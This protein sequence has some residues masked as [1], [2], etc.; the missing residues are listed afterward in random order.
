ML[1]QRTF[2]WLI[3]VFLSLKA[4]VLLG[5]KPDVI[6]ETLPPR[7][8]IGQGSINAMLQD[9]QGF[10]WF[11]TWSGLW[12]YDAYS[13]RPFGYEAGLS[14]SKITCLFEEKNGT[15]WVG[16]R[17]T[18]LYRF[19]RGREIF[20]PASAVLPA[21]NTLHAQNITS[22]FRDREG[23]YWIGAEEGLSMYDPLQKHF[24]DIPLKGITPPPSENIYLYSICQTHDG[25]IWVGGSHGLYHAPASSEKDS[26]VP[27]FQQ[28]ALHPSRTL[29]HGVEY[30]NFVYTVC[31]A[32]NQ[33]NALWIGTKQGLKILD[34]SA[35]FSQAQIPLAGKIR[36]FEHRENDPVSLS[37]NFAI[38]ICEGDFPV[39]NAVWV[40]T[41]D[42][43][44]LLDPSTGRFEHFFA[45]DAGAG[46]LQANNVRSLL[47]DQSGILWIGTHRGVNKLNPHFA[48]FAL[49]PLR[50]S[51]QSADESI[52]FLSKTADNIWGSSFGGGIFRVPLH[53]GK[54]SWAAARHYFLSPDFQSPVTDF[55]SSILPD[56]GG[57][58][59]CLTQG[60]GVFRFREDAIPSGGGVIARAEQ[61]TKGNGPLNTGDDYLMSGLVSRSGKVWIGCWDAGLNLYDPVLNRILKFNKTSDN[62]A[63]FHPFPV[64]RL[65]ETE[66]NGQTFLWAGTRGGGLFQLFFDEKTESLHLLRHIHRDGVGSDRMDGNFIASILT[67]ERQDFWVV[68]E[69]G[70]FVRRKNRDEFEPF[71]PKNFPQAP[72]Y[73]AIVPVG[74]ERFWVS[75]QKGIGCFQTSQQ[76]EVL[77]VFYEGRNGLRERAFNSDAFLS[78]PS[79]ELLF[80]GSVGVTSFQPELVLPDPHVPRPVI[81]GLRLFNRVVLP[82]IRTEEGF[83]LEKSLATLPQLQL[84]HLDNV[85]SF[86]FSGL[87][88]ACPEQNE[89]AYKLEGFDPDWIYTDASQ[90][91][92]HYTNLPSGDYKFL[93]KAAN[94]DG[95]WNP[96]PAQLSVRVLPPWWRTSWAYTLYFVAFLGLLW[97]VRRITLLRAGYENEI[98]IE[99][100]EKQKLEEVNQMKLIF[101]TNI[102]HELKTPLTLIISPL[103]EIIRDRAIGGHRLHS[104]FSMMH[105]NAVRLLLMINQLLDIRKAEA[106]L[107][108][109]E[110][111]EG[112]AVQFVSEVCLSFRELAQQQHIQFDFQSERPVIQAWFDAD[113]LEKVFF[114]VLSNA[115]KF[116]PTG[117]QVRVKMGAAP[118]KGQFFV[119]F[120]DNGKGIPEDKL[121]FIFERFFRAEEH[122][123]E[124]EAGGTGIGLS[125]VK[126]IVE[127]HHGRVEVESWPGRGSV[128]TVWL[129]LG[130]ASFSENEKKRPHT[131]G[132]T[133]QPYLGETMLEITDPEDVARLYT[134][135][136]ALSAPEASLE[137]SH[138]L[139]VEDNVDIREYIVKNLSQEYI[140]S[141]AENGHEGLQKTLEHLPDLILCD[142]SMPGMDGLELTRQLKTRV[143]TSH[144]P[145]ILLTA[146]TSL[147]FKINGLETG[148]DGYI[149]K[150]FNLRLLQLRIRNLIESRRRLREKY[151]KTLNRLD[152]EPSEVAFP[153]MDELFLKSVSETV[154]AHLENPEFSVDDL[155]QK[156][157]MNRKQVYRKIKA[158]T[159][160]TPN[161]FIRTIRLQRAA[162]LLRTHRYTIAEVTY[163]VGFQDLKYFRERFRAFFGVNPSELDA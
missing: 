117:G 26:K 136:D 57:N 46:S 141:E 89:F 37:H 21:E 84:S 111:R 128:F 90:R 116:T 55:I 53:D 79:G 161:E 152:L 143:E 122:A 4:S 10:L 155:A 139:V 109:L 107:M 72:H 115:F 80:G 49:H 92:A 24:F 121:P 15:L 126:N 38:S 61:F 132:K 106:G 82:G 156:L 66:E 86:E 163:K 12:R 95:V 67:D 14:S 43:L 137:K 108:K 162:Q 102:S 105:R 17:N 75:A 2:Y 134:G 77:S 146:R 20:E 81:T 113:Q 101:F 140:V 135:G 1:L 23:R 154:E 74:N 96:E 145:I 42:G 58:L 65:L 147:I 130:D 159:D 47:F 99:R 83:L 31:A 151:A 51:K 153:E 29:P 78:L 142:I 150:P 157:L 104:T 125:L 36:Y 9:Q 114:N 144:I 7:S 129:P 110:A 62:K 93:V 60:A 33:A 133:E 87:H 22:V 18:G 19:D 5:Q 68:T 103:E 94:S 100:L 158:L 123:G 160:Q 3:L 41:F 56:K 91:L 119:R 64:V 11:G 25:S 120:E 44:N 8:D 34:I 112:N 54:P 70:L 6:F 39:K 40:A 13:F 98:K 71:V 63:D 88:Y 28:I 52:S 85:V 48:D 131:P 124:G 73:E 69:T 148:A 32:K 27:V 35:G 127:R 76:R 50:K 45:N 118:E 30:H 149:T 97:L 16:T 138:I 59:W